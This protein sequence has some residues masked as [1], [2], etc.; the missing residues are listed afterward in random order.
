M[1]KT[2]LFTLS[3]LQL[4]LISGFAHAAD[5]TANMQLDTVTVRGE[6]TSSTHRITTKNLNE[7]TATDMK[8]V[9]FNEPSV[10]FGAGNGT[11]QWLSIRGMGQDQIDVKIDDAYTDGHMFH[12]N[13]R[14][15]LD[16]TLVKVVAVQKGTGSA[17]AGIGATS[18]AIVA[19]TI[20]AKDLLRPDQNFGFKVGT[21]V[22][23][24]KGWNRNV[25]LYGKAG[26]FDFLAAGNW[27]SERDYKA[28]KDYKNADGGDR[29]NHSALGERGL[30]AK[31]GFN[32]DEN[33][34]ITLSHRQERTYGER[35][36]RE[37]FDFSQTGRSAVNAPRYRTLTQDTTSLVYQ[38]NNLG[39]A[40]KIK[41]NVYSMNIKRE[42]FLNKTSS[43][44]KLAAY[45]A[46]LG[47]DSIIFDKHTLK[48]GINWR[49]E[50]SKPGSRAIKNRGSDIILGYANTVDETKTD[51][52][53]YL[54]GIW[55]FAPITLT[56]GLRYDYFK[57]KFSDGHSVSDGALNP[58]AG[59]IY[60]VNDDL[61]F[62]AS[63]NYATRSP[64][65]TEVV[66]SG[67]TVHKATNNLKAE[68]SRNA[69]I[70]F[71]Y[72]LNN[73]WSVNGSYFDQ[74]IKDV[75]AVKNDTYY[76]G[77]TLKNSGYELNTVYRWK[78]LTARAGVAY[79]KPKMDG[80]TI[81]SI[82]TA[83]PM[84]RTWT[85]GLAYQFDNPNLEIG[86][87]G[88]FVQSSNYDVST[89]STRGGVTTTTATP[90]KRSGYG[91]NDL[92]ANWKPT[93]KDNLNVNFA[94]NNVGNKYY[95]PH[96][97]RE[98]GNGNSLPEAGRDF[99]LGMNYRF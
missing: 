72:N 87:R 26:Q 75:Q 5:S 84:G 86:W 92:Y 18:G 43:T 47:L 88:R 60:D 1:Q 41:A 19:Q 59:I 13:G 14:F 32:I 70:G 27:V 80:A 4:A 76:N 21:G 38:G 7:S 90:T 83:I 29:V 11:S 40:D 22:S 64:R 97:Q 68:K 8:D 53:A 37:E 28:G 77:G 42:E 55:N 69:E 56:T 67:G 85:T 96:S 81:D 10:S 73:V 9:L 3:L 78:G 36:L 6:A 49:H 58:S 34:R 50:E 17:S 79:N 46:N 33:Q 61:S 15:L 25:A 35:A 74:K 71:H 99:R 63:L 30:L 57:A 65:L 82:V 51:V 66:L 39:F 23:S 52:G 93:G 20:D 89:T 24:N 98:S 48:Y 16:P 44:N 95:K 91:V 2:P 12:H 31:I 45:G 94:V 62:N 54:E